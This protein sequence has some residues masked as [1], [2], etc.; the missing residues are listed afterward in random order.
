M[1]KG[2][3][4]VLSPAEIAEKTSLKVT[5]VQAGLKA[6]EEAGRVVKEKM[7]EYRLSRETDAKPP[8]GA[9]PPN[10]A[11]HRTET[12]YWASR[13]KTPPPASSLPADWWRPLAEKYGPFIHALLGPHGRPSHIFLLRG[14]VVQVDAPAVTPSAIP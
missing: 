13:G 8:G 4:A 1:F 6:L 7:G 9:V 14:E 11:G 5:N 3:D 2:T 10:N 12:D